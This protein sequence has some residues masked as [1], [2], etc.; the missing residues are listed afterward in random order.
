VATASDASD[1]SP[2]PEDVARRTAGRTAFEVYRARPQVAVLPFEDRTGD[3]EQAFLA[4]A[5]TEELLIELS[6]IDWL[7]PVAKRPGHDDKAG[8]TT[9]EVVGAEFGVPYVVEGSV[10]RHGDAVRI[11]A[12]LEETEHGAKIWGDK[13]DVHLD[14]LHELEDRMVTAI[15]AHVESKLK[16]SEQD[17]ARRKPRN[18]LDAWE[19]TQRAS[20]HQQRRTREDDERAE[21]LA[22]AAIERDPG[23]STPHAIL[24][25]IYCPMLDPARWPLEPDRVAQSL[26]HARTAVRL[27]SGDGYAHGALGRTL[28][29]MGRTE[30]A[31]E[32][33]ERYAELNPSSSHARLLAAFALLILGR[34]EEARQTVE[35]AIALSPHD[36]QAGWEYF[37]QG[38][39]NYVL[40]D[41]ESAEASLRRSARRPATA[42]LAELARAAVLMHLDRA[43]DAAG[44]V[45]RVLE[46]AG[47]RAF[48]GARQFGA[49]WRG[50]LFGQLRD[51]LIAA[52]MAPELWVTDHP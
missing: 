45:D 30:A 1:P 50:S 10:R 44:I 36:T 20:W 48:A 29:S 43:D 14:E 27:D 25:E 23:Y 38:L 7:M 21:Q 15:V 31:L 46:E 51:D 33:F 34:P 11:T 52:G 22:L 18:D 19:L 41:Y 40:G 49:S 5:I 13:F 26:Q 3:P 2:D 32:Q 12:V 4:D 16:G 9:A 47:P 6:R 24:A 42:P 17:R 28:M 37:C 35:I 39:C 8:R